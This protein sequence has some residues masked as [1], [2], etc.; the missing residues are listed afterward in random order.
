MDVFKLTIFSPFFFRWT[1]PP[2]SLQQQTAAEKEEK[3]ANCLHEPSDIR[4]WKEI[5]LSE[6]S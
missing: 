2:Q 3:I 1:E 4:T 5:P 6:V